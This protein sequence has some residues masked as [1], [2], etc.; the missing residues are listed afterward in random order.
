M[1]VE[2]NVQAAI[3]VDAV[4]TLLTDFSY[5]YETFSRNTDRYRE[6]RGLILDFGLHMNE[7]FKE[8]DFKGNSVML[9]TP[10]K[11]DNRVVKF[12]QVT[13]KTDLLPLFVCGEKKSGGDE[14]CGKKFGYKKTLVRHLAEKH[15]GASVPKQVQEVSDS[16]TC[17]MCNKKQLREH[18]NRHLADIHKEKKKGK[19]YQLRGF[20]TFDGT[21]W[22]PLWLRKDEENPPK[23]SLISA[24]V[25]KGFIEVYGTTFDVEES[26]LDGCHNTDDTLDQR[27]T[28]STALI[29]GTLDECSK[30][31]GTL[32]QIASCSK[33]LEENQNVLIELDLPFNEPQSCSV[34]E[35]IL[36]QPVT[37]DSASLVSNC[38]APIVAKDL[39]D[40][41]L[42]APKRIRVQTFSVPVVD[43]TFWS[44]DDPDSEYEEGDSTE[45]TELRM[46]RKMDRFGR[47][48]LEIGSQVGEE[49]LNA[50]FIKKFSDYTF[51]KKPQN[52][53]MNKTNGHLFTY[54][55]SF[56]KFHSQNIENYNLTRHTDCFSPRFLELKDPSVHGGWL[57]SVAGESGLM[58]PGRRIEMLKA[59]RKLQD[60]VTYEINN[61]NL[62]VHNSVEAYCKRDLVLKRLNQISNEISKKKLFDYFGKL[63]EDE[64]SRKQ[65][66]IETLDPS[67]KF[68]EKNIVKTWSASAE[69]VKEEEECRS[70]YKDFLEKK[71]VGDRNF[72]KVANLARLNCAIESRNRTSAYNLTNNE[73]NAR[74]PKWLPPLQEGNC[75]MDE[76]F[77]KIPENWDS[78]TPSLP[79]EE[80]DC[81]IIKVRNQSSG[82]AS[83]RL[84]KGQDV[85]VVLTRR[86][87]E[88]CLMFKDM[89]SA[90]VK[91]FVGTD[92][93]F[94]NIKNEPL[95]PIQRTK[96]SLLDKMA[97]AC[98]ISNPTVNS[99]R[100]ASESVIQSS[101]VLKT[102]VEKL[103]G[104]SISVGLKYYDK[105]SDDIKA[106]YISRLS[107]MES[108][109][110]LKMSIPEEIQR[111]RVIDEEKEKMEITEEAKRTLNKL[112]TKR[113][114]TLN[115]KCKL[116]PVERDFLQEQF[117]CSDVAVSPPFPGRKRL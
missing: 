115:K 91:D 2:L 104:H 55:D 18:I 20:L 43:G 84:K 28:C 19:G 8:L 92:P 44:R 85:D 48:N 16:V 22:K 109:R 72:V 62:E 25:R 9:K 33:S 112:K 71:K 95:A 64:K 46:K 106:Q 114:E 82:H 36:E 4:V 88:L 50:S 1:K 73:F 52:S 41:R 17:R 7:L 49:E 65:E 113:K 110:K 39:V 70:I 29:G 30:S 26:S 102:S 60:F 34:N 99:F 66:A 87:L 100:R 54:S 69:A 116:I 58:N 103:Q 37:I 15:P 97:T 59:F 76:R 14:K 83:K 42:P 47:R 53:T 51:G 77:Q 117:S 40:T 35:S 78:S 61:T 101:P 80:P 86:S 31:T 11:S 81:W 94:V 24:P 57:D 79:D 63:V 74:K 67:I 45:F 96:G 27:A 6:D 21:H 105:S 68:K 3:D 23:E 107:E 13:P 12:V 56:L 38:K 10:T 89:K 108:P 111:K 5:K 75:T 90:F 98:D 32:D 93:F